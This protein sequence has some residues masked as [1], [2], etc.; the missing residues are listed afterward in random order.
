M[1]TKDFIPFRI[2]TYKKPGWGYPKLAAFFA[3][4][5]ASANEIRSSARC[6]S[7]LRGSGPVKTFAGNQLGV[8]QAVER[9]S[10]RLLP[11]DRFPAA[12]ITVFDCQE[13]R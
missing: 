8:E 11:A 10:Q 1:K 4:L 13:E 5:S 2:N 7:F 6:C 12:Q 9:V 3:R